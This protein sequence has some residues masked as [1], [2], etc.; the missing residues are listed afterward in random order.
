[1]KFFEAR[2]PLEL[3]VTDLKEWN[4]T[5]EEQAKRYKEDVEHLQEVLN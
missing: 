4:K 1:M 3:E 2:H 5:L